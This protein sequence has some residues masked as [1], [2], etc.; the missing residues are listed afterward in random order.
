MGARRYVCFQ[1]SEHISGVLDKSLLG[2][3]SKSSLFAVLLRDHSAE[4]AALA[5]GRNGRTG[6]DPSTSGL[7]LPLLL[8]LPRDG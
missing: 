4:A 6:L 7:L 1:E 3:G 2:G 5:M 8:L